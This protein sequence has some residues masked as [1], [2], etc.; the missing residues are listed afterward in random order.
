MIYELYQD[1]NGENKAGKIKD[2]IVLI[3]YSGLLAGITWWLGYNPLAVIGLLLGVRIAF[4]DYL[5]NII[6]YQRKVI[7]SQEARKWWKY[8]GESTYWWDHLVGAVDW[9]FRMVVRVLI[10]AAAVWCYTI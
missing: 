6:L 1:R 5:I 4:F 8:T 3:L 2:T 7:E 10:F 9:R